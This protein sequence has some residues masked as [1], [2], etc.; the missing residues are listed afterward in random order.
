[1]SGGHKHTLPKKQL[2][3]AAAGFV[4]VI[5]VLFF[6]TKWLDSSQQLPEETDL[7]ED[8]LPFNGMEIEGRQYVPREGV[9]SLL[10]YGKA[11]EEDEYISFIQ[12]MVI[13]E[14]K[15]SV[16]HY[17]LALN[18]EQIREDGLK[19]KMAQWQ[20]YCRADFILGVL[21]KDL[22]ALLQVI[23]EG[24]GNGVTN[25]ERMDK[26]Q[27][28]IQAIYLMAQLK[29]ADEQQIVQMAQ[30]A[31]QYLITEMSVNRMVNELWKMRGYT[32]RGEIPQALT[33][34]AHKQLM[35]DLFWQPVP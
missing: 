9:L 20:P 30:G 23:T 27:L 25:A 32:F 18:G 6:L 15:Q 13:D 7:P 33:A 11:A 12:L 28:L 5:A 26:S 35:I 24:G 21:E 31:S 22:P 1:M 3:M 8:T 14:T 19:E 17:S 10:L 4:L 2:L 16:Q 29:T 34:E